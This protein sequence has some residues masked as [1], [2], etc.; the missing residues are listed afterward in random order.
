MICP[1]VMNIEWDYNYYQPWS[2]NEWL[3][4]KMLAMLD[5]DITTRFLSGPLAHPEP[6]TNSVL[7]SLCWSQSAT[8][9]S[10][11]SLYDSK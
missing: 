7:L 11:N 5:K 1:S 10:N 9:P 6:S 4:D 2:D 3:V 8:L